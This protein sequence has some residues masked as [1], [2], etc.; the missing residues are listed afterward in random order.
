[1]TIATVLFFLVN[2]SFLTV[3]GLDGVA[4]SEAVAVVPESTS[5]CTFA[6]Y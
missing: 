3:M 4:S 2:L 5:H 1:M 6:I